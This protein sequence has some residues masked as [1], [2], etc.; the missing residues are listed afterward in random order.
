MF[1]V[2]R[3]ALTRLDVHVG[4]CAGR[5]LMV[6]GMLVFLTVFVIGAVVL[7]RHS[8]Q[9]PS[10]PGGSN[11]GIDILQQRFARGEISE[12]EYTRTLALLRGQS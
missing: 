9:P 11:L 10:G 6:V 8:S 1:P 2:V 5:V 12:E 3:N 4:G 7:V